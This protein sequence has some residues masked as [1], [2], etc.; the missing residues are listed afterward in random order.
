MGV[1]PLGLVRGE[2]QPARVFASPPPVCA[3]R[4][5]WRGPLNGHPSP[6]KCLPPDSTSSPGGGAGLALFSLS[7]TGTL[8]Y[9]THTLPS[10]RSPP[11]VQS[12]TSTNAPTSPLPP[13]PRVP[14]RGPARLGQAVGGGHVHHR[15]RPGQARRRGRQAPRPAQESTA[16][17]QGVPPRADTPGP[18]RRAAEE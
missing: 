11:P 9:H 8:Q 7:L 6:A 3:W 5:V 14:A 1:V 13:Q 15:P 18:A 16:D 10:P 2:R 12:P 4:L 17:A